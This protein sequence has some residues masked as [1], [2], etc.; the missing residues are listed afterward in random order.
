MSEQSNKKSCKSKP[1]IIFPYR[2]YE[3]NEQLFADLTGI[4]VL[5]N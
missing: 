3:N 2:G 5:L 4:G 1:I